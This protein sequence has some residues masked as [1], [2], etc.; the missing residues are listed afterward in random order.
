MLIYVL[1]LRFVAFKYAVLGEIHWLT[2][3]QFGQFSLSFFP[4]QQKLP[5]GIH[6]RLLLQPSR[7]HHVGSSSFFPPHPVLIRQHDRSMLP[8]LREH[9]TLAA[10]W[11]LLIL[12]PS[13]LLPLP[14][15][16]HSFSLTMP[17]PPP[18]ISSHFLSPTRSTEQFTCQEESRVCV[19]VCF[20][21]DLTPSMCV[22]LGTGERSLPCQKC[23]NSFN[24]TFGVGSPTGAILELNSAHG[25]LT[26]LIN[27]LVQSYP[28]PVPAEKTQNDPQKSFFSPA[29]NDVWVYQY[30]K[31]DNLPYVSRLTPRARCSA[32]VTIHLNQ[33]QMSDLSCELC[34]V[35]TCQQS[36]DCQKYLAARKVEILQGRAALPTAL[37]IGAKH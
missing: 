21:S 5:I 29:E 28:A 7:S 10:F 15:S 1:V 37:S 31:I 32:S 9:F 13:L 16:S 22:C 20:C 12:A 26:L 23:R 24:Y 27:S 11:Y 19:C 4:R 3:S 2:H 30:L 35:Q 14:P 34:F 17:V 18:S 33:R 36:A 25:E 8:C 6:C